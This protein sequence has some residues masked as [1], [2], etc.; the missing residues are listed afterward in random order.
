LG[1]LGNRCP[2]LTVAR[3]NLIAMDMAYHRTAYVLRPI[4]GT[5]MGTDI[6][7]REKYIIIQS[8]ILKV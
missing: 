8:P 7:A 4:R 2:H 6:L 5:T 1:V 3:I